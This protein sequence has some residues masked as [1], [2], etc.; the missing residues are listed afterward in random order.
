MHPK[1]PASHNNPRML[2]LLRCWSTMS[3]PSMATETDSEDRLAHG[4]DS[5]N[6]LT[7]TCWML[8]LCRISAGRRSCKAGITETWKK[9][10]T[11][12]NPGYGKH[13]GL[14]FHALVLKLEG[15]IQCGAALYLQPTGGLLWH[16]GT[17]PLEQR[18][19]T[20]NQSARPKNAGTECYI[21]HAQW[22]QQFLSHLIRYDGHFLTRYVHTEVTKH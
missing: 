11:W 5:W 14:L 8:T 9:C 7:L 12:R 22:W 20:F 4:M 18:G 19:F 17:L 16:K 1:S 6:S 10:V 21:S 2:P 3:M 13:T 15:K